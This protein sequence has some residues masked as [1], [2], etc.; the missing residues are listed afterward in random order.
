M[1]FLTLKKAVK[2]K[3][4][5][6]QKIDPCNCGRSPDQCVYQF[7]AQGFPRDFGDREGE[8]LPKTACKRKNLGGDLG[9]AQGGQIFK[10]F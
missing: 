1:D 9:L 8:K 5:K 10:N 4:K 3:K 7:L 2:D 6:N